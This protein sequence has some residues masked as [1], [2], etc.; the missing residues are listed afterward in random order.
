[1][2]VGNVVEVSEVAQVRGPDERSTKP[3]SG[4]VLLAMVP[5]IDPAGFA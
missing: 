5:T 2:Q 3:A 1:M 4:W